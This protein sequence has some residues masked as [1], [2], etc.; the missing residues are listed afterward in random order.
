MENNLT[1]IRKEIVSLADDTYREFQIKLLP[2]TRKENFLGVRLPLLRKIARQIAKEWGH[3]YLETSLRRNPKEEYFEEIML[4]GMVIGYI[5]ED[6]SDIF[7]YTEKF[8]PKIDNWSV[9]DSFCSGFKHAADNQVI[10]WEWLMGLLKSKE[11]YT[12]RYGI[13][14]LLDYYVNDNYINRLFP[15]FDAVRHE[16]YY[17]KMAVAW[18][19]SICYIK[20]PDITMGYLGNNRLDDFT[21]NKALQKIT[22]SRCINAADKAAIKGLRRKINN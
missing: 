11:E 15:L 14:M 2:D 4:Q 12:L 17:V 6:I 20:Y 19:V 10:V 22:E 21:Y 8:L 1:E 13:V 18:A 7:V 9:C 16:G 3:E 5:R